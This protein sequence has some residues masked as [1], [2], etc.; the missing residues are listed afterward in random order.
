MRYLPQIKEAGYDALQTSPI[1]PQKDY[2]A[3]GDSWQNGW[4]KLYQPLGFCIAEKNHS[5]GTKEE[6]AAMAQAAHGL[7]LKVIVDIVSNHLAG[8]SGESFHSGVREYEPEIYDNQLLHKGYG[9][10]DDNDT[11]KLVRGHLG[12]Y[13]D[14]MTEDERV[15]TAIKEFLK[16]CIDSGADGFRFDA[17]KHIETPFD[18]EL[19]SDYW[20]EIT[21]Y[22]KDYAVETKGQE[23][24]M[25]AEI[26]YTPGAGR[27]ISYYDSYFDITDTNL[28]S[29]L[30]DTVRNGNYSRISSLSGYD[31][32][33]TQAVLWGESHDTFANAWGS[34]ESDQATIDKAYA[35]SCLMGDN[36]VLY[37][38]RPGPGTK[39]GEAGSIECFE[40]QI[41]DINLFHHKHRGEDS[42]YM[43][44]GN[45]LLARFESGFAV[46]GDGEVEI[47]NCGLPDGSYEDYSASLEAEVRG[48]TLK[49]TLGEDGFA[50]FE[51][52]ESGKPSIALSRAGGYYEE[53]F[54]LTITV[55]NADSAS[56]TL[57]DG[58]P[59]S[60]QGS[61]TLTIGE[62]RKDALLRVE[63]SGKKGNTTI[64]AT[65][66]YDGPTDLI[67]VTD[68]DSEYIE[69][70]VLYAWVWGDTSSGEWRS[71]EIDGNDFSFYVS[72][73]DRMFLLACFEEATA[74]PD[75]NG[76]LA[77]TQDIALDGSVAFDGSSLSWMDR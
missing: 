24:Y 39:L 46:I 3:P 45:D 60:F 4:W 64:E 29:A 15:K 54:E 13:P 10:I 76:A 19:A 26:L 69:N 55:K 67:K 30:L 32:D 21:Q 28:S 56:Y 16:E 43:P 25:Y 62:D 14:L 65:Y 20:P 48:G 6:F 74:A 59:V 68:I 40:D 47:Q 52:E 22:A 44:A 51:A 49:M 37:F 9:Y 72:S 31:I 11:A 50:A 63:A 35:L 7:G 58:E 61:A 75:W 71:G 42:M 53:P 2:Y 17:A 73:S 34:Q 23:P 38:A 57:N 5:L 33:R 27:D 70:H 1:Q 36:S 77:Q 41:G 66:S 12:D 8:G 18:G